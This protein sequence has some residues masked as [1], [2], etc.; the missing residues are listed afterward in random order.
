MFAVIYR[1]N[2]KPD[3]E[4]EFKESW[5]KL[6]DLLIEF[7]GGLGS[8]LHKSKVPGEF[9]AYA[10]WKDRESWDGPR[11]N[12]PPEAEKYRSNMREACDEISTHYEL[13]LIEDK[14]IRT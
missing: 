5:K 11:N 2:V 8:S 3:K 14:L 7:E 1:F 4:E 9:I 12:L 6:T 10:R 13:E